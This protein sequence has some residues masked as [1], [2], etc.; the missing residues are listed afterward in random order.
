MSQEQNGGE[1]RYPIQTAAPRQVRMSDFGVARNQDGQ[2]VEFQT[3]MR[4]S[5]TEE[6]FHLMFG[7]DARLVDALSY[8]TASVDDWTIRLPACDVLAEESD[9]S[10][11]HALIRA[12][13]QR[14]NLPV[15]DDAAIREVAL[16]NREISAAAAMFLMEMVGESAGGICTDRE[17]GRMDSEGL[18]LA[19]FMRTSDDGQNPEE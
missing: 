10:A 12:A 13:R 18:T 1:R 7:P 14:D 11:Q 6:E 4:G 9:Q 15:L 5:V 16:G 2:D 17:L 19:D 8:E 3:L